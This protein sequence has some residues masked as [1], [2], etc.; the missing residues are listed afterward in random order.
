MADSSLDAE[1][2]GEG[3]QARTASETL[4][5]PSAEQA[6]G[7][8]AKTQPAEAIA[9]EQSTPDVEEPT[10]TGD[11][12]VQ[13]AV[14]DD[15]AEQ[16]TSSGPISNEADNTQELESTPP[17]AAADPEARDTPEA[18]LTP[19]ADSPVPPLVPAKDASVG[20]M[21]CPASQEPSA[22]SAQ[23]TDPAISEA[24]DPDNG[25]ETGAPPSEGDASAAAKGDNPDTE[26]VAKDL[27]AQTGADDSHETGEGSTAPQGEGAKPEKP[28]KLTLP[29]DRVRQ[30]STATEMSSS[31]VETPA[32]EAGSS[33]V[34]VE[35]E[36]GTGEPGT[37]SKPKKKKKSKKKKGEKNSPRPASGA[38]VNDVDNPIE[39]E[40]KPVPS[41]PVDVPGGEGDG[42]LVDKADSSG[43]DSAVFVDAS[44]AETEI[45]KAADA[46]TSGSD[47]WND[48]GD[49]REVLH[50]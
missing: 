30:L 18:P 2:Q 40:T 23:T 47:E 48:W 32:D 34:E 4:A 36:G 9:D 35:E 5:G 41:D 50:N 17:N 10:Q 44:Q 21:P 39:Q 15:S 19:P 46:T 26:A 43:E 8:E 24:V 45:E 13:P 3:T 28:P 6:G 27:A 22:S 20:N 29:M 49:D 14:P 25:G 7:N 12:A 37:P 33:A 42:V 31:S 16:S 1:G 11:D 38:T